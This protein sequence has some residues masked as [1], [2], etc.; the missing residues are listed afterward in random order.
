M[1]KKYRNIP[2]NTKQVYLL[3]PT[4]NLNLPKIIFY[5]CHPF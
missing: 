3:Q 4:I 5:A 2:H 1:F